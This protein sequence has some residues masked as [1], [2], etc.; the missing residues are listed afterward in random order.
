MQSPCL[1]L[2]KILDRGEKRLR[3]Q[4]YQ[5]LCLLTK[6]I[7][8]REGLSA[9]LDLQVCIDAKPGNGPQSCIFRILRCGLHSFQVP[10]GWPSRCS[11]S[12]YQT[13]EEILA[14]K[15]QCGGCY[16][17]CKWPKELSFRSR[18]SLSRGPWPT[19]GIS[20]ISLCLM[21]L[22]TLY[23]N[24]YQQYCSSLHQLRLFTS[25]PPLLPAHT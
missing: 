21:T 17:C 15:E 14:F 22:V 7:G 10:D 13:R 11:P 19:W 12:E 16:L 3:T 6:P 2:Q 1:I 18:G 24:E 8:H 20:E 4:D 23:R 5:C 9:L 25:D